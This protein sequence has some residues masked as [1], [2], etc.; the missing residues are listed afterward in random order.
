MSLSEAVHAAVLVLYALALLCLF[1]YGLN[2]YV[3]V[4][5]RSR[6]RAAAG[7]ELAALDGRA[8]ARADL[9]RVTVQLP[10]YNERYVVG[11]LLQAVAALD[12]PRDRL[13]VQV[14]DDSTDDTTGRLESLAARYRAEGLDV[15]L[16]HRADRTGFKAG[17]LAAGLAR[18]TGAFV[19]ILDAD[20]VPAPDFLRRMMPG[21]ADPRVGA[22]QGRWGHV[23]E[24]YSPLTRGQA[25]A[26]DGHFGVEQAARSGGGLLLTFNGTGGIWRRAAI[27]DAGG[28]S[29]D[30]LTEDLDLSLRA[31]LRGWRILF[32][33]DVVCPAELPV[34]VSAFKSQQHRWA[35]GSIQ[36]ARKLLPAVLRSDRSRFVKVQACL[37]VLGYFMHPCM[38]AVALLTPLLAW[39]DGLATAE[40]RLLLATGLFGVASFGPIILYT[41][42]QRALYP[43]GW[44]RRLR[45]LPTLFLVGIGVAVN[46]TRGVLEALAGTGGGFV[47]TPKFGIERAGDTWVGRRYGVRFPRSCLVEAAVALYCLVGFAAQVAA[48]RLDVFQAVYA[49]SFGG[50]AWLG[51]REAARGRTAAGAAAPAGSREAIRQTA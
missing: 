35:K 32:R 6:T 21:F 27:D 50:V 41:A 7:A 42:A 25:L 8:A 20:A 11:R 16:L 34:L 28:W 15:T 30:T 40:A 24:G 48:G 45:Y 33:P 14:L 19:A 18:A 47:R 13:E 1:V 39:L 43:K 17:A 3:L 51:L 5:L 4:W 12:W 36:V 37:W 23:N 29:G 2:C 26:L 38:L 49:V 44:G 46:N 10:V 22:V 31:Q 9:P